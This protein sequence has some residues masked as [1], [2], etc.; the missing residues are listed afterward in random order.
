MKQ[1]DTGGGNM[2]H[3]KAS[4]RS[5]VDTSSY[6]YPNPRSGRKSGGQQN[7]CFERAGGQTREAIPL[8]SP[9]HF[10]RKGTYGSPVLKQRPRTYH[11]VK[12]H[13]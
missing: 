8:Y 9:V 12:L 6:R 7:H 1:E 2:G 10:L 11:K 5:G 4:V 13:H 3:V